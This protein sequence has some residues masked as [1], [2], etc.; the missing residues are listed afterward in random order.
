M[1]R[2]PYMSPPT[3]RSESPSKGFHNAEGPRS[4]LDTIAGARAVDEM[5][6]K[7]D[8]QDFRGSVLRG[9]LVTNLHLWVEPGKV[10]IRLK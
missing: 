8:A 4:S 7:H 6:I 10:G 9:H 3:S 2:W 1:G 5:G